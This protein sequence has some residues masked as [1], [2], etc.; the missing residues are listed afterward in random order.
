M[1]DTLRK[2]RIDRNLKPKGFNDEAEGGVLMIGIYPDVYLL[3]RTLK[4]CKYSEFRNKIRQFSL[5][6]RNFVGFL[7]KN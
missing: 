3:S 6:I 2:I 1:S 7:F 5:K 4:C